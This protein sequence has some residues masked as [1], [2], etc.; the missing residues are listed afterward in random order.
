VG[1]ALG[2]LRVGFLVAA[3][4]IGVAACNGTDRA[5]TTTPKPT[6]PQSSAAAPLDLLTPGVL[7]IGTELPAPLFWNGSR[8]GS[9]RGGFESDLATELAKRLGN[10]R[11]R[12]VHYPFVAVNAGAPCECDM[13]LSQISITEARL[14]QW[15]FTAPYF[16]ADQGLMTR[17]RENVPD[18]ETARHLRYGEQAETTS[19]DFLQN[20]VRPAEE[21]LIFDT[22]LEMFNALETGKID[23]LV[24]DTPILLGA[25]KADRLRN[26]QIVAQFK[27][28]DRYAG[29]LPKGS[30]NLAP[31]NRT[32]QGMMRDGT[33]DL[34]AAKYF[35]VTPVLAAPF[36]QI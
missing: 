21:P 6:D 19:L 26:T 25:I 2:K 8:Y 20:E 29:M 31:V 34:L 11:V 15:D 10:L 14:R 3:L 16:D 9:A 27:T 13:A 24:F 7:T 17:A 4:C 33:V 30:R 35:G 12:V 23:A 5:D 22:T 18:I 36:W 1:N 28:G 32:L